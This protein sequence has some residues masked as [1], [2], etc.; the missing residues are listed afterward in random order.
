MFTA[1]IPFIVPPN[2]RISDDEAVTAIGSATYKLKGDGYLHVLT[3]S[4]FATEEQA[5]DFVRRAHSALAWLLLF[6]GVPT[7]AQLTPQ[8]IRYVDD[9]VAC[10]E[11]LARA[12][13]GALSGPVDAFIHGPEA[14][15]YPTDKRIRSETGLPVALV[16]SQP[17]TSALQVLLQGAEFPQSRELTADAKLGVALSLYGAHFTET[18]DNARFLTLIMALETCSSATSKAP[19]ALSL[20]AN[21]SE[22]VDQ[23]AQ[24][25]ET[26]EEDRASL[27][28]LQRELLHRREDSIRSQVRKLVRSE[29]NGDSD[30]AEMEKEA[31]R[32]Y[33]LRSTLVHDGSL[34]PQALGPALTSAKSLVRRVLMARYSNVVGAPPAHRFVTPGGSLGSTGR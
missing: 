20:L 24:L 9:P 10:G 31:V 33:D 26:T 16:T 4:G 6:K 2:I 21:W 18:S 5:R 13:R 29:L 25:P 8:K 23:I 19:I 34:D 27:D 28:A 3:A 7:E 22:Q 30:A 11:G 14:A 12:T 15:I 32:L 1:R 17:S